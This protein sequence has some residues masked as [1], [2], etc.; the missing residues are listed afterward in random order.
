M[1]LSQFQ[2][3]H[4]EGEPDIYLSHSEEAPCSSA[5]LAK[6]RWNLRISSRFG[7][8]EQIERVERKL[9]NNNLAI[10]DEVRNTLIN[11][12]KAMFT[13]DLD[14]CIVVLNNIEDTLYALE[15][16]PP[17]D[18][19]MKSLLDI[20][21]VK[22]DYQ[23]SM[24]EKMKQINEGLR[25]IPEEEEVVE[26]SFVAGASFS[27][28]NQHLAQDEYYLSPQHFELLRDRII[29]VALDDG[30]NEINALRQS[31]QKMRTKLD[32]TLEIMKQS[33]DKLKIIR[34]F[35]ATKKLI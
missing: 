24:T 2:V 25:S 27:E 7:V 13:D 19:D 23:K 29:L 26:W 31:V 22:Y 35:L 28:Q 33:E 15:K 16:D 12:I 10:S 6:P 18:Y 3:T 8:Q 14:T 4:M 30:I 32:K 1:H 34:G 17:K 9:S 20:L 21:Q 11:T 5:I